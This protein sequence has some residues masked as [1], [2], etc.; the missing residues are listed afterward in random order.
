MKCWRPGRRPLPGERA[1]SCSWISL[2]AQVVGAC[3]PASQ[4]G[5]GADSREFAEFVVEMRLVVV[6][7]GQ[8]GLGPIHFSGAA[9]ATQH[10]P[11]TLDA[12]EG[13]RGKA[14]LP[15][16]LRNEASGAQ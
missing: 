4:V 5:R 1:M 9:D 3:G 16:E 7:A 12:T 14:H 13:L 2:D 6:A 15:A 8:R 10:L 11:K